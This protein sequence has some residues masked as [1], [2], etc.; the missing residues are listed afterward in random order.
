MISGSFGTVYRVVEKSNP[1]E[2]IALK[3]VQHQRQSTEYERNL[4]YSILSVFSMLK[5]GGQ[6]PVTQWL[7]ECRGQTMYDKTECMLGIPMKYIPHVPFSVRIMS[8]K[9][10]PLHD[11][12]L[13]NV[14][15]C[16]HV[17]LILQSYYKCMDV[18]RIKRYLLALLQSVHVLH[19]A[20]PKRIHRYIY[21]IQKCDCL[22]R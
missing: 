6:E 14:S 12:D 5:A 18:C 9:F 20:T 19:I 7:L 2:E 22:N 21:D 15:M 4:E 17:C 11:C 1:H 10:V 3:I 16:D 8:A 13:L